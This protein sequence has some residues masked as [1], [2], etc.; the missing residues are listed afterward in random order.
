MVRSPEARRE[1]R[2]LNVVAGLIVFVGVSSSVSPWLED[3]YGR[4]AFAVLILGLVVGAVVAL[5]KLPDRALAREVRDSWRQN[6]ERARELAEKHAAH[7]E[8]AKALA[9]RM[10][11]EK[12]Q[13]ERLTGGQAAGGPVVTPPHVPPAAK[14]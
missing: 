14:G 6:G 3:L 8:V 13:R 1:R 7:P 2:I 12:L 5:T 9:E 10:L 4:V 11:A